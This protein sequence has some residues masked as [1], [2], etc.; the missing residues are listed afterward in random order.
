MR[1]YFKKLDLPTYLGLMVAI[2]LTT[3]SCT[4]LNSNYYDTDGIYNTG[5]IKAPVTHNETAYYEEY[6]DEK[7]NVTFDTFTDI[8]NYSSYDN[9]NYPGWGENYSNTNIYINSGF[10]NPYW[11]W[12]NY[13]PGYGWNVGFG[14]NN[15]WGW[16]YGFGF[17]GG[18]G[19]GKF[20]Y[21]SF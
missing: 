3:V 8:D 20:I 21:V 11:G 1:T 9:G 5:K 19:W 18:F 6:F 2:G 7:Q 14:Y 16:N 10:G 12:N 4:S 13:Y 15:Y 17:G